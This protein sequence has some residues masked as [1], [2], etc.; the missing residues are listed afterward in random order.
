MMAFCSLAY[1]GSKRGFCTKH[2]FRILLRKRCTGRPLKIPSLAPPPPPGHK[3]QEAR[4]VS[5]RARV[6]QFVGP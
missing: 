1:E 4:L 2:T 6:K 3:A 5:S